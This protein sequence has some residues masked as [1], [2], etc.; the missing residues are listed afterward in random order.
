VRSHVRNG[1]KSLYLASHAS[2]VVGMAVEDGRA[3]IEE[4]TDFATQPKYVYSHEW[5]PYDLVLWDDSW[6]MHRSTEYNGTEPRIMR[7]GGA[8]E[9]APV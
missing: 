8:L 5:E 6:T 1:K 9:R 7:W 4:L 3:L 2:H